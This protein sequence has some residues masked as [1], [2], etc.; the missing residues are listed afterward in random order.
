MRVLFLHGLDARPGGV[1]PTYLAS[2]GHDVLNPALPREDFE[3]SVRI[4]QSVLDEEQPEIVVGSSRGGAVALAMDLGQTPAV[5]LAPAW[6]FFSIEPRLPRRAVIL[7]APA[8]TLI[9]IEHSRQLLAG[10]G[11]GPFELWEVGEGHSLTDA[12]ALADLDRAIR[13][14]SSGQSR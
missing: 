3:E 4:G 2:L 9:P 13:Q 14:L 7:H 1:K 10:A 5:L 8:D 12:A 11:D 6:K